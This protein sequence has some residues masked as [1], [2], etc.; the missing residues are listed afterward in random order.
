MEQ[1]QYTEQQILEIAMKQGYTNELFQK[2]KMVGHPINIEIPVTEKEIAEINNRCEMLQF[3]GLETADYNARFIDIDYSKNVP[4]RTGR[5]CVIMG[6]HGLHARIVA[7]FEGKEWDESKAM[8]LPTEKDLDMS[9]SCRREHVY[10][11]STNKIKM[12]YSQVPDV[13][14]KTLPEFT[15]ELVIKYGDNSALTIKGLN[16]EN[17]TM[18]KK[19]VWTW[20]T[21]HNHNIYVNQG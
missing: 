9:M 16:K 20:I 11:C 18:F 13:D 21:F 8:H 1:Q 4:G 2:A 5:T 15:Y 12:D 14:P 17:A 6:A 10:F 19:M 7:Q 3:V